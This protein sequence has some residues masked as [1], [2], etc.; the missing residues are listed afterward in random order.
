MFEGTCGL[1]KPIWINAPKLERC[2]DMFAGQYKNDGQI[3][4]VCDPSRLQ[5]NKQTFR[6][7]NQG[8][9]LKKT[10]F[11][12]IIMS[13]E[14]EQLENLHFTKSPPTRMKKSI[15]V[16]SEDE[17]LAAHDTGL[18]VSKDFLGKDNYLHGGITEAAS[19]TPLRFSYMATAFR[20]Y[21]QFEP[22][23]HLFDPSFKFPYATIFPEL[24]GAFIKK[25]ENGK[26]PIKSLE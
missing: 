21:T 24:D 17:F 13:S 5:L 10:L 16:F 8:Q 25:L 2:D 4:M 14:S 15:S 9:G 19:P 12:P 3:I 7:F 26:I 6:F 11:V 23:K 18:L 1:N 20:V 22:I